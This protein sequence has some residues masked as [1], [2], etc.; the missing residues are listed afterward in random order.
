MADIDEPI[1]TGRVTHLTAQMHRSE[2]DSGDPI[3]DGY[4]LAADGARGHTWTD[5]AGLVAGGSGTLLDILGW[6]DAIVD[7]G[8]AG[9]GTTDD[10]TALTNLIDT[11]TASGTKSATI[12]FPGDHVYLLSGNVN[13]PSVS[14]SNPQITL[15]F[16]GARRP[17]FQP[18]GSIPNAA[19]YSILRGTA[20]TGTATING[21]TSPTNNNIVVNIRNLLCIANDNPSITF[22]NLE[23]TYSGIIEG[24]MISVT[25]WTTAPTY[26]THSSVYGV[27]LPQNLHSNGQQIDGL[28]IGGYWGCLRL[29]ELERGRNIILGNCRI[30]MYVPSASHSGIIESLQITSYTYGLYM[31][32]TRYLDIL[33]FD[34]ERTGGSFATTADIYDPGDDLYG[35][36]RWFEVTA[37]VGAQH[38]FTVT[39]GANLLTEEIGG[40]WG[41]TSF[42]TPA[43]VLGTAAAD[44]TATSAIRTDA[45]IVAFDATAPVTQAIGD[46]AATGS[47]AKAARRDHK[48][49]MP[50]FGSPV[51]VGTSNAA[52]SAAT[53]AR[54]DHVHKGATS[55]QIL[56][57]D[58]PAGSPLVFSDLIQNEAGTDLV[59]A[60]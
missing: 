2:D 18:L 51:A 60:G 30:G 23:M 49:G 39:G 28:Q 13:L 14:L 52:G 36:V 55:G 47:A 15:E 9:D 29:G 53:V 34:T 48:H 20:T 59:Y 42:G 44:G 10:T 46:S 21:G 31:D 45:T 22:W 54:S 5:P 27:T 16:V 56:V 58:T 37:G 32:G 6:Y 24:L 25:P 57:S 7:G 3:P 12:Y 50:A 33:N 17:P 4:L 35:Y 1:D 8:L 26:P 11:A 38:L 19:G 43:V 40:S 41:G